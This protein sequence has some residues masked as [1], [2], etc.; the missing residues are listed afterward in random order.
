EELGALQKTV[1]QKWTKGKLNQTQARASNQ[2]TNELKPQ[3]TGKKEEPTKEQNRVRSNANSTTLD[4]LAKER[5]STLKNLQTQ[6]N[7]DLSPKNNNLSDSDRFYKKGQLERTIKKLAELPGGN[8]TK[9]KSAEP[10][11]PP[12]W[13]SAKPDMAAIAAQ[14][15]LA[16]FKKNQTP[17]KTAEP[18]KN[19]TT[20]RVNIK[21]DVPTK[22]EATEAALKLLN[23]IDY[24]T[25]EKRQEAQT[26]LRREGAVLE[27]IPKKGGT[28]KTLELK[29]E[30]VIEQLDKRHSV[31]PNVKPKQAETNKSVGFT[32]FD[33]VVEYNK[34]K[35]PID[36]ARL[37]GILT[38]HL[39][40]KMSDVVKPSSP[41]IGGQRNNKNQDIGR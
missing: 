27:F 9:W 33:K 7:K 24:S 10:V 38:K 31:Q 11:K 18:N 20:S 21:G 25:P 2:S 19:S 35:P 28:V 15:E 41:Q 1:E 37:K 12:Q 22:K 3:I 40:E 16:E 32:N 4:Q 5:L 8:Q 30:K 36:V 17:W 39:A 13:K 6:L 34:E 26:K 23:K 14:N 29:A